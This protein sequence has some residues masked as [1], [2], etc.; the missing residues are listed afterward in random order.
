M[1]RSN[2]LVD[3]LSKNQYHFIFQTHFLNRSEKY[4]FLLQPVLPRLQPTT[5][6]LWV[7]EQHAVSNWRKKTVKVQSLRAQ[8]RATVLFELAWRTHTPHTHQKKTGHRVIPCRRSE[9]LLLFLISCF[10]FSPWTQRTLIA[11]MRASTN[12][13]WT[14]PLAPPMAVYLFL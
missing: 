1:W 8:K 5:N 13:L 11:S 3:V 6:Q 4:F 14:C 7:Y 9:N 2:D 10:V 12:R